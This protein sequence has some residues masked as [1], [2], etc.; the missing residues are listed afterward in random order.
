MNPRLRAYAHN[1]SLVIV[2]AQARLDEATYECHLVAA[3]AAPAPGP[4]ASPLE[5]LKPLKVHKFQ[6]KLLLPPRLAPFEFPVDAQVGMKVLLTCSALEGQQPISFVWL[7]DNQMIVDASTAEA[8]KA[9]MNINSLNQLHQ[10]QLEA[11]AAGQSG[12]LGPTATEGSSSSL[13]S[14]SSPSAPASLSSSLSASDEY[15][16]LIGAGGNTR[17]DGQLPESS[18]SSSPQSASSSSQSANQQQANSPAPAATF[19]SL[20]DSS[21]RVRQADD[22]SILSIDPLELKHSGRFTCSAQNE[23]ARVSHSSH[24]QINGE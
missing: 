15:V 5:D 2:Q 7:K 1:G 24:L 21:I 17:N 4:S 11:K 9:N 23:A 14:L 16:V 13:L 18:S 20:S 6:V 12:L 3:A 19:T 8:A 22:Y 10:R